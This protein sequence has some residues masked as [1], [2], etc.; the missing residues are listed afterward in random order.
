VDEGHGPGST[1]AVV[2]KLV[3]LPLLDSASQLSC[4]F[5][6][7]LRSCS[8]YLAVPVTSH[9]LP[10]NPMKLSLGIFPSLL[11]GT[12]LCP[13]V[14]LTFT[15]SQPHR[16]RKPPRPG[17]SRP[18][19]RWQ[20]AQWQGQRN[21]VPVPV[22]VMLLVVQP[23][24]LFRSISVVGRRRCCPARRTWAILLTPSWEANVTN[25]DLLYSMF[26]VSWKVGPS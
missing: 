18:R 11:L 10:Q 8:P 7:G 14:S 5:E 25:A 21:G 4:R 23:R 1:G 19:L 20:L 3:G 12:S 16:H 15:V 24:S 2:S 26:G 13:S 9:L 6:I 17:M 22:K